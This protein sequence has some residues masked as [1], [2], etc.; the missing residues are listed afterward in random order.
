LAAA[1]HHLALPL[2]RPPPRTARAPVTTS[3]RPWSLKETVKEV[4]HIVPAGREG[5]RR[6]FVVLGGGEGR[7]VLMSTAPNLANQNRH[8]YGGGGGRH[9]LMPSCCRQFGGGCCHPGQIHRVLGLLCHHQCW[10][11][12]AHDGVRGGCGRAITVTVPT[13]SST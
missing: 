6:E 1:S 2:H 5:D 8:H 4:V 10:R 3:R 9:V 7:R 11:R 13:R 12:P